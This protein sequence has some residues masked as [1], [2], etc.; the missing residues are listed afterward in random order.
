MRCSTSASGPTLP[1]TEAGSRCSSLPDETLTIRYEGACGSCPSSLTGTLMAIE[2]LIRDEI[3]PDLSSSLSRRLH[4]KHNLL[5]LKNFLT[6]SRQIGH[7]R[8]DGDR[9]AIAVLSAELT[10]PPRSTAH[11]PF[12]IICIFAIMEEQPSEQ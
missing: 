5:C 6:C 3:D 11:F 4:V 12:L 9:V 8:L 10:C 7:N 1:V 2:N